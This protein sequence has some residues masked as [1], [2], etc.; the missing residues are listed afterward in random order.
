MYEVGGSDRLKLSFGGSVNLST[1]PIEA[2]GSVVVKLDDLGQTEIAFIGDS[3]I[4][5]SADRGTYPDI[6][7]SKVVSRRESKAIR[8]ALRKAGRIERYLDW[9]TR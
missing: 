5:P 3:Y 6:Y 9:V 8:K 2:F 7:T 4:S 1:T